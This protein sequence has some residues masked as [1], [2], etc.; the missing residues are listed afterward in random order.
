MTFGRNSSLDNETPGPQLSLGP[1]VDSVGET[2]IPKGLREPGGILALECAA[3]ANDVTPWL[4][5]DFVF[6]TLSVCHFLSPCLQHCADLP[7]LLTFTRRIGRIGAQDVPCMRLLNVAWHTGYH[8][9]ILPPQHPSAFRIRDHG[10]ND[11]GGKDE[12][13]SHWDGEA[14]SPRTSAAFPFPAVVS[15]Y[16]F[17]A[18]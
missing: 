13:S 11:Q 16:P 9:S 6:S 12:P 15:S 10:K 2:E 7:F 4:M 8:P 3:L 14:P 18:P 5:G 1:W 17:L